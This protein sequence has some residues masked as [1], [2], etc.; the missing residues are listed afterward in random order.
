MGLV[1]AGQ[2]HARPQHRLQRKGEGRKFLSLLL[3][4]VDACRLPLIHDFA[5]DG[6]GVSYQRRRAA[7]NLSPGRRRW[8]WQRCSRRPDK[9]R[10]LGLRIYTEA[11]QGQHERAGGL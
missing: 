4:A 11:A 3:Q 5:S 7:G 1:I 6:L 8:W 10:V 9:R 2:S